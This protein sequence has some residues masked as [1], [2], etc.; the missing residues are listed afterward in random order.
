MVQQIADQDSRR[1]LT[2]FLPSQAVERFIDYWRLHSLALHISR[3]RTSKLGDYRC[4]QPDQP[5]HKISVNGDLNPYFF[6]W[7]LLHEMAH[8]DTFE[9]HGRSVKP[10]GHE[11]QQAYACQ[12]NFYADCFTPEVQPLIAQY[13]QHIPL[14][15]TKGKEIESALH[16]LDRDYNP[17]DKTLDDLA[18]GFLFRLKANPQRSF[19][20]I[21]RRRSRWLCL[22]VESGRKYLVNGS[23]QVLV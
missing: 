3:D 20:A 4:P 9:A 2:R 10:H 15:T 23:A 14:S 5:Q 21:E 22:E 6:L 13:T 19:R 8:L 11:W 1:V 12:L 17:D 7:V 16:R 18:P